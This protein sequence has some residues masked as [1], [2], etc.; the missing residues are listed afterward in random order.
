MV[1]LNE[2][3]NWQENESIT[4][5]LVKSK[6]MPRRTLSTRWKQGHY[7][8]TL[9]GQMLKPSQAPIFLE[10]WISSLEDSHANHLAQQ[11]LGTQTKT[12]DTSF[13]P[14]LNSSKKPNLIESSSKMLK[15][16]SVPSS[17]E[18]IGQTP[19]ERLY[20][21]MCL[22]SWSAEV[23]KQR[24][25]Y[26][27][28]RKLGHPTE[29]K[30]SLSWATP[31]ASDHIE[32]ARTAKESNQK[33]L[34]RDLNR[35]SWPTATVAGLVEGKDGKKEKEKNWATP[36]TMDCLPQ[37]G[38]EALRRQATTTRKGRTAPANL[39]EQ[40]H[41]RACEIYKEEKEKNWPSPIV[42]DHMDNYGIHLKDRKDGK[43]RDDTLPRKVYGQQDQENGRAP[44]NSLELNPN[45]VEQLMGIPTEWTDLGSWGT[46]LSHKQQPWH[47]SHSTR[48][49]KWEEELLKMAKS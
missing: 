42:R 48:D 28:R 17:E 14:A 10:K 9:F 15:D 5:P 3:L 22:E 33:C 2:V 30:G 19:K 47:G 35:M 29:E 45:W 8:R 11:D 6:P 25:E 39:R 12:L 43:K 7:L 13:L 27:Q 40:V 24:G 16:S 18:T 26:S 44:M 4:L 21:S 38:E 32:G 1:E 46:E 34:G 37:R 36:N 49:L 41:P 31:Q 23:T 20:S